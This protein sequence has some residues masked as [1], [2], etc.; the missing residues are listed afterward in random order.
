MK[1]NYRLFLLSVPFIL[2][3]CGSSKKVVSDGKTETSTRVQQTGNT[4]T[5]GT[6]G[7]TSA[8]AA[9]P[10]NTVSLA[11]V[12]KVCENAVTA[13]NI[14]SNIDFN[15]KVGSKDITVGGKISMRQDEVI[16]IQ[17]T[18]M[19]LVEVGRMEFTRDSVLIMDRLHKQYMKSSYD[20]VGFLRNNGINFYS[21]QALFRN[22]LFAP[23]QKTVDEAQMA[24]FDVANDN[25]TRHE[26]RIKYAWQINPSDARINQTSAVYIGTSKNTSSLRW[27]YD[28]F[29]PLNSKAFP[30]KQDISINTTTS[31][32][33][34]SISVS[35]TMKG[36]K[37]D[38]D[39][40]SETKV[41]SKY[42]PVKLENVINQILKM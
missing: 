29:K 10:V 39:W 16:R 30:T 15:I 12:R 22:Q 33:Q 8:S 17:L 31:S 11:L 40:E 18:P 9:T 37:T 42:K 5:A 26:G 41:P 28:D 24:K 14:V 25:V 2:T 13:P 35:I 21:L 34:K 1:V 36:L 3:A 27:I 20:Q 7:S 23:G 32:G 6:S 19:G 38:S 4:G